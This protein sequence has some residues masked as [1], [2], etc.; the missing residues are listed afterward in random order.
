MS[1]LCSAKKICGLIPR[2]ISI[3]DVEDKIYKSKKSLYYDKIL[4]LEKNGFVHGKI[5]E[6]MGVSFLKIDI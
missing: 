6:I 4:Q 2:S 3:P 5:Y 1:H